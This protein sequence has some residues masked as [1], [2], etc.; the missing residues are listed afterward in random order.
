MADEDWA[1]LLGNGFSRAYNDEIF[2]YDALRQGA[3]LSE[4]LD[5]VFDTVG[6]TDFE[7]VMR[8]LD[9]ALDYFRTTTSPSRA[10]PK[11]ARTSR[12]RAVP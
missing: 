1:L 9:Q 2:S 11:F 8:R 3:T 6:T 5:Q 4:R 7:Q 12:S 10:G